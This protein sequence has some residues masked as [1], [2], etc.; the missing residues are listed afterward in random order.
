MSPV[1]GRASGGSPEEGSAAGWPQVLYFHHVHPDLRHYTSL[2]PESF[3]L[4]VDTVL[5]RYGDPLDPVVALG[6]S[7]VR[8]DRPT[9]LFTFDDGHRDVLDH[10]IPV[11]D[12]YGVRAVLFVITGPTQRAVGPSAPVLTWDECADLTSRGHVIGSHTVSHRPLP[13]LDRPEQQAE[14]D[15]G[16]RQVAERLG[17]ARPPLAYPYGLV[18]SAGVQVPAGHLAF[19]TVKAEPRPWDVAPTQIRRSYLPVGD[20]LRWAELCRLW[21]AQWSRPSR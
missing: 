15:D 9:V 1:S 5:S 18:P 17:T 21:R 8:P 13:E 4:A 7:F 19:G 3:E 2:T 11:L 20:E 6:A 12:R 10:G 16:L 14:V